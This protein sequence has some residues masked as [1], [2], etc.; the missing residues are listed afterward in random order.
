MNFIRDS[1]QIGI[2]ERTCKTVPAPQESF[3]SKRLLCNAGWS[4]LLSFRG[5]HQ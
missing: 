4:V 3:E 1:D 5:Q 2:L